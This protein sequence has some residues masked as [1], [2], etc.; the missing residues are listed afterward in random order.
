MKIRGGGYSARW[1]IDCVLTETVVR[2][3][4]PAFVMIT[5]FLLL[6]PQK[7]M[8]IK[9]VLKYILRMG[10]VLLTVGYIYCLIES[11]AGK[12]TANLP[13]QFVSSFVSLLE[14]KSWAHMWYVYMLIGM[15]C[16]TP[17][18]KAA[19]QYSSK[20]TIQFT[21]AILFL[22]TILRSTINSFT[23]MNFAPLIPITEPYL[24]YYLMGFY[25]QR[26]SINKKSCIYM[27]IAGFLCNVFLLLMVLPKNPKFETG[28]D[29]IFIML[30]SV[31]FFAFANGNAL[32]E[33]MAKN[34]IIV[35]ISK[36][37]FG[38]YLFHPFF[39]NLLNKGMH[40]Y[41]DR[42]P[43]VI[44]ELAFFAFAF[45]GAWAATWLLTRIKPFRL[46]LL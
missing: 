19:T 26:Y 37:S 18:L 27:M 40:L 5:G 30:F 13:S 7:E 43:M 25:I 2:F 28:S 20:A 24:F 10:A 16:L 9:K 1:F 31:G 22:L 33:K 35:S 32:L 6:N 12:G 29:N 34:K 8:S 4:V 39:M 21:L 11:V 14:G 45:A 3:A 36:Y 38:I 41:P 23:G 15:Y 17:L 44:G 46:L 42:L